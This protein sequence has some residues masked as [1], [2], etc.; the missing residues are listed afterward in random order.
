DRIEHE[1]PVV[2]DDL[3]D[4][5]GLDVLGAD[6][7]GTAFEAYLGGAG[8]AFLE[9]RPGLLGKRGKLARLV[10]GEVLGGGAR[11][12]LRREALGHVAVKAGDDRAG[13]LDQPARGAL[14]L[15]I[16]KT[17]ETHGIPR[18]IGWF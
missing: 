1:R 15:G 7:P 9:E 13:L 11:E 18:R 2:V 10:T 4:R 3:D 5:D 17:F 14:A 6:R 16:E 8:L 12:Q